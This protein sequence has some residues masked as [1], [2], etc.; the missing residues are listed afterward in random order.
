[1]HTRA[2]GDQTQRRETDSAPDITIFIPCLNEEAHVAGAIDGV[3][4]A[5]RE[6][7]IT[8]EV[9]V[10]DDAS[11]DG[12]AP[13]VEQYAAAHPDIAVTV[14]RNPRRMGIAT[15]F[16]AGAFRGRGRY[17]RMV[18]GDNIDP[19]ETHVAIFKA[20]GETDIVLPAYVEIDGRKF[21]RHVLSW[22]YTGIINVLS[23][24]RI[25]YYNGGPVVLRE[26]VERFHVDATGVGFQA[27]FVTRLLSL[28]RTYREVELKAFDR[29]GS[30]ALTLRNLLSVGH[31]FLKIGL[32]RFRS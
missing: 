4:R 30:R 22:I 19:L 11:T 1:M 28:G 8:F 16:V 17:Y 3:V 21:T 14:V 20:L 27:E 31:S 24:N 5:A 9:F 10:F 6:A 7:G 18:N 13:V 25:Q 2:S 23:G 12:T 15:N 29:A 26:D 32:R